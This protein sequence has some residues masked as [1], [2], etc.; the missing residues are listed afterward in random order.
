MEL[1]TYYSNRKLLRITW[2][3]C[4]DLGSIRRHFELLKAGAH[5]ARDLRIVTSSDVEE[6]NIALTRENMLTIRDWRRD[7]LESYRSVK[8]GIY[9]LSPVPAAYVN[10]FSEFFDAEKSCIKL[11]PTEAA[12]LDWLDED[13]VSN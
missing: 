3:K 5:Y 13:M 10:Y 7:A 6:I 4:I 12:A 11:F 2:G 1:H 8:T 9:A